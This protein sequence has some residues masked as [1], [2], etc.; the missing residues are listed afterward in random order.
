MIMNSRLFS[1]VVITSLTLAMLAGPS[2]VSA[3]SNDQIPNKDMEQNS[4]VVKPNNSETSS[5]ESTTSF[6]KKGNSQN[7]PVPPECPKQGPIPPNC[8]MKP[9]F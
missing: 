3:L 6:A 7:S 1:I 9:K 4:E 2:V 8:T 5:S